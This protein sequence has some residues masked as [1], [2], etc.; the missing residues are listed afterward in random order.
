MTKVKRSFLLMHP[1]RREI[2]KIVSETP[3][4]YFFDIANELQLPHGTAFWHLKKLEDAGL[5]KSMKF[6]GKRLFYSTSLRGEEIEKAFVIL[7]SEATQQVFQYIVDNEGC[8]QA[9]ISE[10]LQNHHDT[11]RHHIQRLIDANLIRSEKKG[12]NVFYF[13]SDI[14]QKILSSTTEMI[15]QAYIDHLFEVLEDECLYPEVIDKTHNKLTIRISCSGKDDVY[16]SIELK[17]WTMMEK[18]VEMDDDE[19]PQQMDKPTIAMVE[20]LSRPK[21]ARLDNDN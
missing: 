16:F 21:I 8:Y 20:E 3:G 2:Y 9:Q 1:V 6:A 4:N 5:V 19:I 10:A 14:G 18:T 15:S 12:R 11:I 17:G 13:I 7:K